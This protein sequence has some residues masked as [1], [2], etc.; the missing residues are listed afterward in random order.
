MYDFINNNIITKNQQVL[1]SNYPYF[2]K[3][4][5]SIEKLNNKNIVVI[6]F[7]SWDRMLIDDYSSLAPNFINLKE[8]GIYYPNFYTT[9]LRSIIGITSTFLSIPHNPLLPY[10]HNGLLNKDFSKIARYFN[11]MDYNTIFIQTD[12]KRQE[13]MD[14]ITKY[15][16]FKEFYSKENIPILSKYPNFEKGFDKDG[17]NFLLNQINKQKGKFF[18]VFYTSST[19]M[20]Y[21]VILDEKTKIFDGNNQIE[22]YLNRVSYV[23]NAI[24]D[25]FSKASKKEW[26]N[27]TIFILFSDHNAI[28]SDLQNRK[29]E[30]LYKNFLIIYA[31]N[32]IKPQIINDIVTQEDILPTLLHISGSND[33]FS[34]SGNSIF[35]DEK[36]N[37][38]VIYGEDGIAYLIN[39]NKNSIHNLFDI[40][41]K[42]FNDLTEEEKYVIL[43][44]ESIYYYII[45]DKWINRN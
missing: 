38:K 34:S 21:D 18:A 32:L 37:R 40:Y 35:D 27:D 10:L 12:E 20:P 14:E 33:C 39:D 23:D 43:N 25:F 2:R 41:K 3:Y 17:F 11:N 30:D 16:E 13:H 5:S 24:G 26:F 15:L 19:H 44:L 31:P 4:L 1:D 22:Q 29:N 28:F 36:Q 7:E 42:Q 6:F 9:G 45:N 8:N